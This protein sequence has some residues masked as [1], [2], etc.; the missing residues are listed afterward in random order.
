MGYLLL[1]LGLLAWSVPH[2]WKRFAPAHR[3]AMGDRGKLVVTLAAFVGIA[4]MVVGY[5]MAPVDPIWPESRSMV[6]VNN[7]LMLLAVYLFAASGM[8]TVVTRY[9]R[10]PQLW[11]VRLWALAHLMV[12]GDLASLILFAALFVWAQ[13]EVAF[14]NR[15]DPVWV[16]PTGPANVGKEIGAVIGAVLVTGA[17]GYIH[18]LLGYNP[19]G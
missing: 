5:R 8:K 4:L 9:V 12:N 18:I 3:A 15:A 6:P 10:H 19:F 14:I 1:I 17:A 16:K 7:L 11:G 2:L 13:V